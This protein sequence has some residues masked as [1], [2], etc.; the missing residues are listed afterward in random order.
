MI[1]KGGGRVGEVHPL[2][3]ADPQSILSRFGMFLWSTD[4]LSASIFLQGVDQEILPCERGRIGS[5]KIN[6]SLALLMMR[7]CQRADAN[8]RKA[9]V[10]C[11]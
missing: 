3:I 6:P 9:A 11:F 8:N 10:T 2:V 7:E 1:G 5:V 4:I